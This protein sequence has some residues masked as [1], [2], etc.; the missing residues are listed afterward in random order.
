M[1]FPTLRAGRNYRVA[2]SD[3]AFKNYR[4]LHYRKGQ[5]EPMLITDLMIEALGQSPITP[6][7]TIYCTIERK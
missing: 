1:E 6:D 7:N 3:Y 4:G 5:I 2:I